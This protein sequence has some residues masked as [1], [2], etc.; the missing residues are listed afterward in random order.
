M[1]AKRLYIGT[2][3]WTYDDWSG[4]FYPPEVKG[5]E[6]L[7]FYAQRFNSV[8]VNASFY[9]LPTPAMITAWNQRLPAGFHL[10]LKGSRFITHRKKLSE[11]AESLAAF[12]SRAGQLQ[13]LKVILWQLPPGLHQDLARLEEFLQQ[14]PRAVR[15][16]VELRHA[17]WWQ[18][19]VY[20][21]LRRYNAAFVA[22]SH[23]RL[24]EEVV[25][26]A[27]FLYLRFHGKGRNLYQYDYSKEELAAWAQRVRP[28]LAGRDLY[29]F[30]NN[31]YNANAP[32]NALAFRG[33]LGG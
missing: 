28:L 16:A 20:G 5:P 32:R 7:A 24:P 8:E 6:R 2:S 33:M 1:A 17:S 23:P 19:G 12:W 3:G 29:A 30:F 21:L 11:A 14:L 10:V 31:D 25:P 26:T 18:D 15:H 9:R 27:D 22:V 13:R 4:V